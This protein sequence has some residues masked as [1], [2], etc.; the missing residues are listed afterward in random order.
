[1]NKLKWIASGILILAGIMISFKV[2]HFEY[3]FAVFFLGHAIMQF[4]FFKTK[5]HAMLTA[6]SVFWVIDAVGIY[7]WLL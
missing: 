3:A 2:P 5:E 4:V 7:R 6:N 1:M